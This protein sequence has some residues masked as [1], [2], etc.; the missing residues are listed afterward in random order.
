MKAKVLAFLLLGISP[1]F[2]QRVTGRMNAQISGGGGDGKCTIEVVVGDAADVEINGSTAVIRTIRGANASFR[3]FQCNQQMPDRPNNFRF[4][5]V[6]GRG[7]QNLARSP[8]NGGSA[9]IHIEDPNR[10]TEGYTFDIFWSGGNGGGYNNGGYNN[11]GYGNNRDNG[12]RDDDRGRGNNGGWNNGWGSGSGWN[13]GD[14]NFSGGNS[15]AGSFRDRSGRV[16]RLDNA[17]VHI[18]AN[19]QVNVSFAGDQRRGVH[20]DGTVVSRNDR[21][22]IANVNGEGTSGQME[23][24]MNRGDRVNRIAMSNANLIW[25]Y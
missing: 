13:G 17:T 21:R 6:D 2:A 7:S 25:T 22:V 19:G 24:D 14:F 11:G 12:R 16:R 4:Q 10:G 23:I 18:S 9:V 5:G 3:R 1:V 15:N 8:Q 20:F